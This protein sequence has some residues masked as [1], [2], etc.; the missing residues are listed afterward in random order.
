MPVIFIRDPRTTLAVDASSFTLRRRGRRIGR[1]PPSMMEQVV[2]AH[3][4]EISRNALDRLAS[5]GV[6]VTFLDA[7]GRVQARLVAPWKPTPEVRIGQVAAWINP[8]LRLR[9]ARRWVDAKIANCQTLLNR[10][11]S[12][13]SDE[14]LT[15]I[16]TELR[17]HRDALPQASDIAS[18]LGMEGC[19]ARLWF[20]ALGDMIL[21][22]WIEFKG[23]NRRPPRD[24]TNAT[25]SYSYAVLS[26]QLHS[27]VETVGLDPYI[28]CL[29]SIDSRRPGLVMDLLEPFRPALGDRLML[30]L[31]NLGIL[32]QD[33]FHQ[34]EGSA[35]GVRI[36]SEGREAIL[37]MLVDWM[38]ACDEEWSAG[39]NPTAPGFL[40][41]REAER[42]ARHAATGT[43]PDFVPY[44][45]DDREIRD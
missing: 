13:H 31:L 43:L 32:K 44:H 8:E 42:Y 34:P 27:A 45:L 40:L 29:H 24:P 6:P 1:M 41:Q 11:R 7:S 30:R 36:N 39:K 38:Q 4:V 35:N 19:A 23:R 26:H 16:A 14:T 25:L 28:G 33:H 9:L 37:E 15:T 18:L 22:K 20:S 21:P 3:G 2:V 5:L 12:N 17:K 10:F